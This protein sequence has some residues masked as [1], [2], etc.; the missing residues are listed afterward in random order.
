M[1]PTIGTQAL[2]EGLVHVQDRVL[3]DTCRTKIASVFNPAEHADSGARGPALVNSAS[4]R[5]IFTGNGQIVF[6]SEEKM[7]PVLRHL[8]QLVVKG[9]NPAVSTLQPGRSGIGYN[10]NAV[11]WRIADRRL[12]RRRRG[13]AERNVA[14][15]ERLVRRGTGSPTAPMVETARTAPGK[16]R[17]FRGAPTHPPRSVEIGIGAT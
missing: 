10:N 4:S 16:H 8:P 9:E 5:Q 15:Q 11:T 2:K 3:C 6:A 12:R 13:G 7:L 1:K 17:V 14:R